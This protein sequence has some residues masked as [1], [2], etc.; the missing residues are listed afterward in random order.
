VLV[1]VGCAP[2]M[3][4]VVGRATLVGRWA[5]N[6]RSGRSIMRK[7]L[8]VSGLMLMLCDPWVYTAVGEAFVT[9]HT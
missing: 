7:A 4:N 1:G 9:S 6:V 2:A 3:A 5:P 8:A